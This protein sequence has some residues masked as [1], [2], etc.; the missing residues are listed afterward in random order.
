MD[1]DFFPQIYGVPQSVESGGLRVDVGPEVGRGVAFVR[2]DERHVYTPPKPLYCV[3]PVVCA[4][5]SAAYLRCERIQFHRSDGFG[6][7]YDSILRFRFGRFPLAEA[8]PDRLLLAAEL[9][10]ALSTRRA[11]VSDLDR[12]SSGG[13][14][15]LLRIGL[16]SERP[17]GRFMRYRP[18]WY[19]LATK[20]FS[21]PDL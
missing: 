5:G 21:E 1:P 18:Y 20:A 3:D 6:A 2:G 17:Q 16:E 4:D 12:V 7:D 8:A 11:W 13:G 19:D 15:L 9:E 10:S 14:H